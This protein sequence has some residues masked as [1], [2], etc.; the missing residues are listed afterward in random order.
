MVQA[1]KPENSF[2]WE[3]GHPACMGHT[4]YVGV[5]RAKPLQKIETEQNTGEVHAP[6]LP[7]TLPSPTYPLRHQIHFGF[8]RSKRPAKVL[9]QG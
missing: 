6:F 4:P 2:S 1:K 9:L 8:R 3:C 7:I 5:Y